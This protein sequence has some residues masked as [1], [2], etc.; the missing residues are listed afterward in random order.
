MELLSSKNKFFLIK[1]KCPSPLKTI[2]K[3][4]RQV[5]AV[6]A[7]E[8]ALHMYQYTHTHTHS[9]TQSFTHLLTHSLTH[10]LNTHT[11]NEQKIYIFNA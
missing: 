8:L 4:K 1:K 2:G 9:L 3:G 10:S 7:K 5:C 11:H 6:P